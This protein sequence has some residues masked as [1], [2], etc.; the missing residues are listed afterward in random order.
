MYGRRVS[1]SRTV[2]RSATRSGAAL[3]DLALS[4]SILVAA[5]MLV[6]AL[7]KV[8]RWRDFSGELAEYGVPGWSVRPLAVAVPG[9]EI[10]SVAA[11]AWPGTRTAGA[12]GLVALLTVFTAVLAQALVRGRRDVRCACFGRSRQSISW[13]LPLRNAVLA[14]PPLLLLILGAGAGAPTVG[15]LTASLLAAVLVWELLELGSVQQ[16]IRGGAG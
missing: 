8:T 16:A 15:A 14:G 13:L 3:G 10:A 5:I 12:A 4:G 2:R 6:A 9:A 1:P 11:L 7:L